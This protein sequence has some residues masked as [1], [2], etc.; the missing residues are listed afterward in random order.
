MSNKR[1]L[2]SKPLTLV[3]HDLAPAY[4]FSSPPRP[5]LRYLLNTRDSFHPQP[6]TSASLPLLLFHILFPRVFIMDPSSAGFPLKCQSSGRTSLQLP[7]PVKL[8]LSNYFL[9]SIHCYLKSSYSFVSLLSVFTRME[10]P[11]GQRPGLLRSLLIILCLTHRKC[12]INTC[13]MKEW[14]PDR[15]INRAGVRSC[16]FSF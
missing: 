8:C 5:I 12:S 13:R 3:L 7:E 4:L 14:K 1:K 2:K 15:A 10:I 16:A 9:H 6:F 11:W